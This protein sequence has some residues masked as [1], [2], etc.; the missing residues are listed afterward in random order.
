MD[1]D[2]N[3]FSHFV[4]Y[5]LEDDSYHLDTLLDNRRENIE[6]NFGVCCRSTIISI[7]VSE[8]LI[9]CN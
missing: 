1:T 3:T 2:N 9:I 6:K 4:V 7:V 8:K 5:E